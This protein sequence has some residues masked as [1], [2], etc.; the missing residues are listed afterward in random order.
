M[1][2]L[3]EILPRVTASDR[4]QAAERLLA[5]EL[6]D[7]PPLASAIRREAE[8]VLADPAL[9]PFFAPDSRSEV[10]IVGELATDKGRYAVS[11]R[12]D[13]LARDS[14]GWHLADFKTD[15]KIPATPA[16]IDPA[17]ILQMA[18]YRRLLM[19]MDPGEAVSATLVF[20]GAGGTPRV[21]PIPAPA[22]EQALEGLAIRANPF[23]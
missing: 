18:L 12:I 15:R 16:E 8:A 22:M 4:A 3:L 21:M 2:R 20:T 19:A 5:G 13:R 23:P 1:H 17:Y 10:A 14:A 11:G 9:E 6:A 7:D